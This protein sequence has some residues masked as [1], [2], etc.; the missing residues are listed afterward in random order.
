MNETLPADDAPNMS[1]HW[2]K[3]ERASK[4][5]IV[6]WE[7]DIWAGQRGRWFLIGE[8]DPISPYELR[9]RGWEYDC[10]CVHL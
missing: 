10:P 7:K 6:Q 2:V 9:E 8:I 3:A 4:P 1:Y 5:A